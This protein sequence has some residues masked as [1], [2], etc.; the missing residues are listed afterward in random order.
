MTSDSIKRRDW[1]VNNTVRAATVGGYTVDAEAVARA[2]AHDLSV[3]D[4]AVDLG[5]I[6]KPGTAPAKKPQRKPVDYDAARAVAQQRGQ[7]LRTGPMGAEDRPLVM[8]TGTEALRL[9]AMDRR[10]RILCKP[11]PGYRY[12]TDAQGQVDEPLGN[13]CEYPAFANLLF[14]HSMGFARGIMSYK[15]LNYED[16][17][18]KYNRAVQDICDRSDAVVGFPWW[19]K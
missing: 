19:V 17:K 2:A 4:R 16:R 10:I 18:R 13:A 1:F 3:L 12:K 14:M 15:G 6:A 9:F 8:P 5:E 11:V 7:Q